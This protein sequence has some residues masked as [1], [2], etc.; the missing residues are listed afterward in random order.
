MWLDIQSAPVEEVRND[1][2][3]EDT[4]NTVSLPDVYEIVEIGSNRRCGGQGDVLSGNLGV[5]LYWAISRREHYENKAFKISHPDANTAST[6]SNANSH[7]CTNDDVLIPPTVMGSILASMVTKRASQYAFQDRRRSMT[8]P[9]VINTIGMSFESLVEEEFHEG[10]SDYFENW[11]R[12]GQIWY[13]YI[14]FSLCIIC[15][16]IGLV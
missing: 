5:A 8:T 14:S 4:T 13:I 12:T 2:E 6:A 9:D 10:N 15:C 3:N 11:W 1:D 16:S 7:Q